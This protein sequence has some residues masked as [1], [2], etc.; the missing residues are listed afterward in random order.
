MNYL[1]Q[2]FELDF[3]KK[4]SLESIL[5]RIRDRVKKRKKSSNISTEPEV[6]RNRISDSLELPSDDEAEVATLS[7]THRK[8]LDHLS[9]QQQRSRLSS[10]LESIKSLSLIENTSEIK[11]AALALQLLSNLTENR[12]IAK[13]SKSIVYDKFP[14]QFGNILK[15]ELDVSKAL[16]LVDMLEIGRRKYTNL[17]HHMLS[18][19]IYFPAYHRVVEQRNS[20][21][22]QNII[23]LYPNPATPVGAHVPYAQYVRHTLDQILFTI[24]PPT[25]QDFPL[26]FQIADGLDGSGSHRIYNQSS[27]STETKAVVPNLFLAAAPFHE[28]LGARPPRTK[29]KVRRCIIFIYGY[30]Y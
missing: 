16:F 11:I 22:L 15:K 23:Q 29:S 19:D 9:M 24:P 14:G 12:G 21:I 18:S 26:R 20:I 10:V 8:S 25:A 13:V 6:K 30:K 1:Q 28:Q 3:D 7:V 2:N 4:K 27:T 17:C 5:F